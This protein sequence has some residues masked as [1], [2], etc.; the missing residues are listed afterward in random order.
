MAGGPVDQVRARLD[1]V[2]V[3]SERVVLKKAGKTLKG[4]CPFHSE[5]TPSFIV[6]PDTGHWHCF[7]C[8]AGGDVFGFVMQS[9]NIG[10]ADALRLLAARVGVELRQ[11]KHETRSD[12]SED[13]LYAVNEAA[14]TYFQGMLSGPAGTRARSYVEGRQISSES[15]QEFQIGYAPDSG[16]ALAHHLL[17]EGFERADIL[18]AGIAGENESGGLYDRFRGRL[19]FPIRDVNGKLIGFGGRALS[20]EA[21]PKYLNTSQTPLFDKGGNLYLLDRA[22]QEIRRSGQAV[23]VEGYVDALMAHQFGFKN[24]VASLGTAITDRQVAQ[25]KRYASELLFA[26]DPDVAGQEATARGLSVAMD[27]LDRVTTPVPTWKGFVDYVYKLK[28]TIRIIALPKGNDPDD[29][30]RRDPDEWRRLVRE[31]LPVQDF[32]LNRVRGRHDLGTA[33]GKSAAVDEAMAVIADIPEPV[34]QA[35]YIQRLANLV[36][37]DEAFLLQ[38]VRL[39]RRHSSQRE[40]FTAVR[41]TIEPMA[42]VETYCAALLLKAPSLV[43]TE[44]KLGENDFQDPAHREIFQRLSRLA[45]LGL[46]GQEALEVLREELDDSLRESLEQMVELQSRYSFR[47]E[48]PLD[49]AYRSAAVALLLGNLAVKRQ[50]LEAMQSASE[51]EPNAEEADSL[52]KLEMQIAEEAH[53]LKLLGGVL[54]LRAIHKEVRHGG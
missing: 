43:E 52:I 17:Q 31:A 40:G 5:K 50:H 14:A 2:E 42:D 47:F 32:F 54:P 37:I 51:D 10:F 34:Q 16:A 45:P 46:A 44:P 25:V 38:Q 6:F 29:L 4:L 24:V 30:I 28:T 20:S 27:A 22:R 36:G 13:R 26:L 39:Q 19:I 12:G 48:D 15:V 53:R 3:I 9:Q 7:G 21:Q 23:I 8:G 11:E 49:K 1:L 33:A 35:H 41:K 18:Q